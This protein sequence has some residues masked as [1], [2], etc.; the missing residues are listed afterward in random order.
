MTS[1]VSELLF[2]SQGC[3]HVAKYT[4]NSVF[5]IEIVYNENK[6]TKLIFLANLETKKDFHDNS[7]LW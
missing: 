5:D 2:E 6:I 4:F 7:L 3:F 1:T